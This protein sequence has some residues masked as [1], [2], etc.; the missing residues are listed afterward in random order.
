MKLLQFQGT[1]ILLL[2][3]IILITTIGLIDLSNSLALAWTHPQTLI[4]QIPSTPTRKPIPPNDTVA[5]GDLDPSNS[6]GSPKQPLTA[7]APRKN[8]V[9][10]ES[11]L[12]TIEEHPTF[13]FYIPYNLEQASV[14]KFSLLVWPGDTSRLYGDEFTLSETPGIVS[15]RIPSK[16]ALKENQIYRWRF[17]LY[18]G[19]DRDSRKSLDVWGLVQRVARTT[20]REN[21]V[22]KVRP[23]IWYDALAQ[24]AEDL[25]DS[26]TED[27]NTLRNQWI[28]LLE[29]LESED[30]DLEEFIKAPL[31]GSVRL[32]E[33]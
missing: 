12:L 27:K 16:Y 8:P 2:L 20:E 29:F 4:S 21:L 17:K 18:C 33:E 19:T 10:P 32:T 14:G 24:L 6:C 31:V 7:L 11:P 15:L 26:Q 13:L 30:V 22:N 9:S 5:G 3:S 23:D 25:R 28:E 1:I